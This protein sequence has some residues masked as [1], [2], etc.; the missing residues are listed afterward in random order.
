MKKLVLHIIVMAIAI[1]LGSFM[2]NSL[3]DK[4]GK[5]AVTREQLSQTPL[6][7]FQK[8]AA[9][10]E[11]MLFINYCGSIDSV[12]TENAP[13]IYNKLMTILSHD[14]DF[15]QAYHIG[16]MML[17]V[18]APDDAVKILIRGCENPRLKESSKLPFL[19]GYV[20]THTITNKDERLTEAEKYLEM[21]VRRSK[22]YAEPYMINAL[23]RVRARIIQKQGEREGITI[24]NDKH[25]LL[26]AWFDEWKKTYRRIDYD[27]DEALSAVENLPEAILEAAQAAK[28]TDPDNENILKTI[29]IVQE[30]V[31]RGQHLCKSC[32]TI[33]SPGD[34]FCS[35]CGKP[36]EV[37]GI[38]PKCETV[39]KEK[40]CSNC[41]C[42]SGE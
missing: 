38:C 32:L 24:V 15:E 2:A 8:F 3:F 14:P 19:A 11:W 40:F 4:Q 16:G 12:T 6:G 41:G 42:S 22:P 1:V 39:F 28:K 23:M 26:Y 9:D 7:G 13:I 33:Y 30:K 20:L 35:V 37:F 34:K 36:V 18:C 29:E 27:Y 5:T 17:S 10:I 21:A 31:L 25:A